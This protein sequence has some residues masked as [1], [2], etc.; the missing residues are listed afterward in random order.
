M[1]R[2]FQILHTFV[3]AFTS[4]IYNNLTH[5][6]A[7]ASCL[8]AEIFQYNLLSACDQQ[9]VLPSS[10]TT[11]FNIAK[12]NSGS[13]HVSDTV[14]ATRNFKCHV[15]ITINI[16]ERYSVYLV[17]IK[18]T[19]RHTTKDS[20]IQNI[21]ILHSLQVR[22]QLQSINVVYIIT[23]IWYSYSPDDGLFYSS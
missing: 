7:Q 23:C 4:F 8:L 10:S 20:D 18:P 15:V 19:R 22:P 11:R 2:N 3:F 13:R 21:P 14:Q 17:H 12:Q 9:Q 16:L 1:Q 6:L 5:N